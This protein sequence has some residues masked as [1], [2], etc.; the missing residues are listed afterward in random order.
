MNGDKTDTHSQTGGAADNASK[1]SSRIGSVRSVRSKAASIR[2]GSVLDG[3]GDRKSPSTAARSPKP[4][5]VTNGDRLSSAIVKSKPP[6]P[7]VPVVDTPNDENTGETTDQDGGD[8]KS[9]IESIVSGFSM[10][11]KLYIFSIF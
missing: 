11:I 6:S 7:T 2:E 3:Q 9:E 4:G 8:V 5:V 1:H 10:M